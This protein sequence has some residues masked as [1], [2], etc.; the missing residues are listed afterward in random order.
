M[1]RN[2][3]AAGFPL[4]VW[5]RSVER[6]EPLA[7]QGAEVARDPADLADADVVV[8]MLADADA[9]RQVVVGSGLS[10][11]LGPEA[12]L[13]DMSTIGPAAAQELA[14][15][16]GGT[17]ASFLDAPVSGSVSVAESAQLFAMVGGDADAYARATP[18]LDAMTKGHL[19]LGPAGA[20][21]AM[22]LAVNAMIAVTNEAIAETL[23]LASRWG[24][25]G[26]RAY[27][28]LASGALASP[29]VLY[30]RNAFLHPQSEPVAFTA[31]LM[32]KDVGL[33]R[34]LAAE[35]GVRMPALAAAE[36]VLEDALRDGLAERDMAAVVELLGQTTT[37]GRRP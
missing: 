29:F 6:T 13:V 32:R 35:L 20:G 27:D 28:V 36:S 14:Q 3:L 1:A 19:L 16:V 24:I 18:V 10:G 7:A 22:K 5:N 26:E 17:G 33:A 9:V 2:V 37:D 23:T 8:T 30:K 4:A 11:R 34:K 21:A 15:E 25:D 31:S 12:I